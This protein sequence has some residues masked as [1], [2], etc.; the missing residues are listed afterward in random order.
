MVADAEPLIAVEKDVAA[1]G[2]GERGIRRTDGEVLLVE[3]FGSQGRG[4]KA[5]VAEPGIA[6]QEARGAKGLASVIDDGNVDV[7][8]D[9]PGLQSPQDFQLPGRGIAAQRLVEGARGA[10]DA[11]AVRHEARRQMGGV[12]PRHV[13]D[14]HE[15]AVLER[16]ET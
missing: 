8:V 16:F 6:L 13:P 15:I 7:G 4:G 5:D 14:G 1:G 11:G 2:A 12:R 10:I 3:R 9:G